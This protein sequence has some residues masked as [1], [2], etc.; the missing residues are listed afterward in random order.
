MSNLVCWSNA[1]IYSVQ[2]LLSIS[3]FFL[4]LGTDWAILCLSAVKKLNSLSFS[5]THATSGYSL[6]TYTIMQMAEYLWQKSVY[7]PMHLAELRSYKIN[8][9]KTV[10]PCSRLSTVRGYHVHKKTKNVTLTF[11]LWPWNSIE[12]VKLQ[13]RYIIMLSAAVYELS[14][15]QRNR[16]KNEK[17]L[18]TMLKTILRSLPL[19]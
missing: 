8:G 19:Q 11:D 7:K 15:K 18:A 5:W 1:L 17:N 12:V 2:S 4:A 16:E 14:C 6:Q 3:F 10:K 9:N 13:V